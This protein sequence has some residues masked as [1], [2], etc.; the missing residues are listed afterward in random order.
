MVT[1]LTQL[2]GGKIER[3]VSKPNPPLS[4]GDFF[5]LFWDVPPDAEIEVENAVTLIRLLTCERA[6]VIG[7][8]VPLEVLQYG[9]GPAP[10]PRTCASTRRSRRPRRDAGE[11]EGVP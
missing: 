4:Y 5:E 10:T 11:V 3:V 7:N 2:A 6:G 8:P 1:R 9:V